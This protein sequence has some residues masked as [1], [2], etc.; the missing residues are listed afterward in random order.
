MC[1][2]LDEG[3]PG[4]AW[5]E[6][7]PIVLEDLQEAAL[8]TPIARRFESGGADAMFAFPVLYN[9]HC[10]AVVALYF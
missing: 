4:K 2:G 10:K 5:A 9:G 8:G 7:R 1:F 3:L 6:R